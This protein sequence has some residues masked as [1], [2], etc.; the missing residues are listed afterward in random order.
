N[1]ARAA[2]YG[3]YRTSRP[4]LLA[5]EFSED[6]LFDVFHVLIAQGGFCDCEILYNVA[7][8]TRLAGQYWRARAQGLEPYNPHKVN[9]DSNA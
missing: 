1:A 5:N 4:I 6:D 7:K 9:E 2:C 8:E 3:D